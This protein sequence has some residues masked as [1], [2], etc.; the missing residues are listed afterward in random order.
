M[1]NNTAEHRTL[2]AL[3][4]NA[5]LLRAASSHI[6]AALEARARSGPQARSL[7]APYRSK[8]WKRMDRYPMYIPAVFGELTCGLLFSHVKWAPAVND[9]CFARSS[10]RD[11]MERLE[12][13][14]FKAHW[15]F[16]PNSCIFQTLI[17]IAP[18]IIRIDLLS[19][20]SQIHIW[21]LFT[22]VRERIT[23]SSRSI[24]GL[25]WQ[26]R[27]CKLPPLSSVTLP[28]PQRFGYNHVPTPIILAVEHAACHA[29]RN[30]NWCQTPASG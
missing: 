21:S 5:N 11:V 7:S 18:P 8:P 24:K 1:R 22:N 12:S 15:A 27:P 14:D 28:T 4:D 29:S 6:S 13:R 30:F 17:T 10:R 20:K 16:V 26:L 3:P 25:V 23:L 9:V 19:A 2:Q